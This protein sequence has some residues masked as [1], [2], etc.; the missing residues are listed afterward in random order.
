[1]DQWVDVTVE[2]L[3]QDSVTDRGEEGLRLQVRSLSRVPQFLRL[4]VI[5][6]AV[7]EIAGGPSRLTSKHLLSL[8]DLLGP[9]ATGG[10]ISL[11]D[12]VRAE[13]RG[14]TLT[15][16]RG[17]R[18]SRGEDFEIALD[19]PGSVQVPGSDIGI[20]FEVLERSADHPDQPVTPPHEAYL[21]LDAITPP[22][23][24]RN[25]RRGDRFHP[26]GAPGSRK[27]KDF[28]IDQKVP[29][30]LRDRVPL[31]VDQEGIICVLGF[32]IGERCR[33]TPATRRLLHIVMSGTV[34]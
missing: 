30:E 34:S 13:R 20:R 6:R 17:K 29:R 18:E 16:A 3:L 24:V 5:R 8:D 14:D 22:L 10:E 4:S 1:V 2:A 25:R 31:L 9:G 33:T 7:A 28:F 11:P 21:D 27:L 15:L 19:V 32:V 26:L 23:V 12:G